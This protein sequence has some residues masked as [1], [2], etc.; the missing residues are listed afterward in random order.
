MSLVE[1]RWASKAEFWLGGCRRSLT[2]A[3][4]TRLDISRHVDYSL[5]SF[6]YESSV[7]LAVF[8]A[9]SSH[10]PLSPHSSISCD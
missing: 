2:I 4:V 8:S 5:D 6:F 1:I 10:R 3:L 7:V 9:S